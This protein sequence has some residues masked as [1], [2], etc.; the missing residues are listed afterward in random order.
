VNF[1]DGEVVAQDWLIQP[2][3]ADTVADVLVQAALGQTRMPRTIT[4]R[5]PSDYPSWCQ[6]CSLGKAMASGSRR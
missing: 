4:G 1:D 3:A 2:V 6:S 5:K